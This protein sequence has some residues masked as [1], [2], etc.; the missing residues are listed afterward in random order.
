MTEF[1]LDTL[2]AQFDEHMR[3]K[4]VNALKAVNGMAVYKKADQ[5]KGFKWT[6][7]AADLVPEMPDGWTLIGSYRHHEPEPSTLSRTQQALQYFR[8]ND[9]SPF[10]AA[11]KFGLDPQAVYRAI[12]AADKER[13]PCCGQTIKKH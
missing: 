1:T 6:G 10:A 7:D 3:P 2:L 4:V 12:K 13:C 8:A 11:K 9:V 5:V